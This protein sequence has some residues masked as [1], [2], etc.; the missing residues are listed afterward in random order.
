MGIGFTLLGNT[1]VNT[2]EN[3]NNI[4]GISNIT[5][6][7]GSKLYFAALTVLRR[8]VFHITVTGCNYDP[9]FMNLCVDLRLSIYGVALAAIL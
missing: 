3:R 6:K 2:V 7:E 5:G 9:V 4:L 1:R 8:E